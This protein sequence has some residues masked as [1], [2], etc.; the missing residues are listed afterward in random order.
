MLHPT[1]L[2]HHHRTHSS[3]IQHMRG[4]F[5][6]MQKRVPAGDLLFRQHG[7]ST[8]GSMD[9]TTMAARL[10]SLT[11]PSSMDIALYLEQ[12][13]LVDMPEPPPRK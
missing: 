3:P 8:A 6:L 9:S 11:L 4:A 1:K 5:P 2:L 7:T 13:Q 12:V 10:G